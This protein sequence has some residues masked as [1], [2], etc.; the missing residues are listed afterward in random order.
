VVLIENSSGTRLLAGAKSGKYGDFALS[1]RSGTIRSPTSGVHEQAQA[2]SDRD[3]LDCAGGIMSG[4][5][6]SAAA[7]TS[8]VASTIARG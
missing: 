8:R 6:L 7:I 4:A 2:M 3:Q 5:T 1:V